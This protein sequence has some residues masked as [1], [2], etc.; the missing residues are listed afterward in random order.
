MTILLSDQELVELTGYQW[1]SKQLAAL[2]KQG[3]FRARIN[4]RTGSVLLEREHYQAVCTG[5]LP[6][7]AP[8]VRPPTLRRVA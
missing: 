6:S 5:S 1:P 3:F 7:S 2:K 8:K 4:D